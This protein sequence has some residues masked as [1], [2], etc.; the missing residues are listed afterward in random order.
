MDNFSITNVNI[1]P[2]KSKRGRFIIQET[3]IS[4]DDDKIYINVNNNDNKTIQNEDNN[5]N[6]IDTINITTFESSPKLSELIEKEIVIVNPKL[7]SYRSTNLTKKRRISASFS[8]FRVN[9][10][11]DFSLNNNKFFVYDLNSKN[12]CDINEIFKEYENKF[13]IHN[14]ENKKYLINQK[15]NNI[16]VDDEINNNNNELNN[17][18]NN[19]DNNLDKNSNKNI[20]KKDFKRIETYQNLNFNKNNILNSYEK[21]VYNNINSII[22]NSYNKNYKKQGTI[23]V[24]PKNI[25]PKFQKI[26][27]SS[28]NFELLQ[29][30]K[31]ISFLIESQNFTQCNIL[32]CTFSL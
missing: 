9:S 13:I 5:K 7:K 24:I 29:I 19:D 22:N 2:N 15:F 23:H 8:K 21:K 28:E 27:N 14:F 26:F 31:V 17:E 32:N 25:F 10:K 3:E 1:S 6:I 30:E 18:T 12:F 20:I 11:E 16:F 4:N